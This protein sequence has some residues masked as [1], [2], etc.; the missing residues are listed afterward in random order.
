MKLLHVR[1]ADDVCAQLQ[2]DAGLSGRTLHDELVVRLGGT[3]AP[4]QPRDELLAEIDAFRESLGRSFDHTLIDQF[5]EE[6]R[7]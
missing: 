2:R 3:P 4:P 6:G 5:I 1:V 7:R